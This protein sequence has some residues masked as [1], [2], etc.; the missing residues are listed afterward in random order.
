MAVINMLFL[1]SKSYQGDTIMFIR[2]FKV[3]FCIFTLFFTSSGFSSV[4][5]QHFMMLDPGMLITMKEQQDVYKTEL[6]KKHPVIV[7]LFGAEGGTYVLYRPGQNPLVANP[8]SSALGYELAAI[9]EHSAMDAYELSIQGLNNPGKDNFWIT[10]MKSL[11][12]KITLAQSSVSKLALSKNETVLLQN[13][14]TQSQQFI[15]DNIKQHSLSLA[16][17]NAYAEAIKPNFEK[18]SQMVVADQIQYGIEVVK[19]W[20]TL[21]GSDWKNTYGTVLYIPVAPKN[22]ILL[23]IL[24]ELMGKEAFNKQLFYFTSN[25]YSP[26]GDQAISFL[27]NARPDKALADQVFG[28]YFFDYSGILSQTSQKI[29]GK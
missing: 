19:K 26:T 24:T 17:S 13:I 9:V 22:S 16:R 23:S 6:L 18:L 27:T 1:S 29:I 3:L 20:K 2:S 7:A 4:A 5:M 21:L 8:M 28:Q 12:E 14:F 25:S 11:S 10:K 15:A